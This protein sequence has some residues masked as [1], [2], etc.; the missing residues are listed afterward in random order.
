MAGGAGPPAG[1]AESDDVLEVA[2]PSQRFVPAPS[3]PPSAPARPHSGAARQGGGGLSTPAR[4]RTKLPVRPADQYSL[5]HDEVI[6]LEWQDAGIIGA[7]HGTV[8]AKRKQ[9]EER[10]NASQL[11]VDDAQKW[12][13]MQARLPATHSTPP[14]RHPLRACLRPA[15]G[16]RWAQLRRVGPAAP[17]PRTRPPHPRLS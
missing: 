2:A 9:V 16:G 17:S 10:V 14:L 1:G 13:P 3:T 4:T 15:C 12:R 7:A 11:F 6:L 8:G 5:G